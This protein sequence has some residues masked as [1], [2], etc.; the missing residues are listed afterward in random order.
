MNAIWHIFFRSLI[1]VY[2]KGPER[3]TFIF[4]LVKLAHCQ[5]FMYK[6]KSKFGKYRKQEKKTHP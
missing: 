3:K 6:K 2:T 4:N 5:N 1:T